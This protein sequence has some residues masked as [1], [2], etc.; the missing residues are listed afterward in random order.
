MRWSAFK[1]RKFFGTG[2]DFPDGFIWCWCFFIQIQFQE[3]KDALEQQRRFETES[4]ESQKTLHDAQKAEL[5]KQK[6]QFQSDQE[7]ARELQLELA[8]VLH[9]NPRQL[10]HATHKRESRS[11]H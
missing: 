11:W 10:F 8:K 5:E 6:V 7:Q 3:E 4:I 2:C 1:L 9:L